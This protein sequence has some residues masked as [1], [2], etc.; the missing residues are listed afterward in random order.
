MA[1]ITDKRICMLFLSCCILTC[2]S[3]QSIRSLGSV[4]LLQEEKKQVFNKNTRLALAKPTVKKNKKVVEDCRLYRNVIRKFSWLVGVGKPIDKVTATHLPFYYKLSLK[5]E[6][7]HWQHIEAMHGETLTSRHDTKAYFSDNKTDN[8]PANREW[9]DKLKT[10][11]QWFIFS[12]LEGDNVVEERSYDGDRNMIYSFQL[13][14]TPD[15]RATGSYNNAWGQPA[16]LREDSLNVYGSVVCVTYDRA[17]RDSII[18]YLDGQ[19]FRKQNSN[20]ADRQYNVYDK[21][22]RLVL[23]TS[24]NIVGDN[25]IDNWG[26]CG[27]RYVY[28]DIHNKYTTVRLDAELNPMRMPAYRA[29]GTQTFIRRDMYK[30]KWGRDSVAVMLDAAGNDD[31]TSTGIHKIL[32]EYDKK[33]SLASTSLYGKEGNLLK[34]EE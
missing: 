32:Y 25:I 21:Q 19:G 30:D 4:N 9:D 6:K 3:A 29:D 12:D 18:D 1:M 14:K 24:H 13:V 33:G 20:G 23:V 31:A 11:A 16:D 34:K 22:D 27:N 5:N 17:G 7:G 26:N 8:A 15:G 28:D 10:I 2:L